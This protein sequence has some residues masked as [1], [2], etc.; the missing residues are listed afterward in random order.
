MNFQNTRREFL[1]TTAS[2]IGM[3]ALGSMLTQD[4]LMT[5]A[6][7]SDDQMDFAN[8]LAPKKPH[9][10]GPAKACIFIFGKKI[11]SFS[12]EPPFKILRLRQTGI[13][14]DIHIWLGQMVIRSWSKKFSCDQFL[15]V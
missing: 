7:A 9:F 6:N 14:K 5:Q 8:P 15:F 2:G 3:A 4:G 12:V 11:R 13:P 10:D 1:N